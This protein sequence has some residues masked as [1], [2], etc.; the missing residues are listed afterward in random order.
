M[1]LS[2]LLRCLLEIIGAAEWGEGT[3]PGGPRDHLPEEQLDRDAGLYTADRES[4]RRGE[5]RPFPSA[6]FLLCLRQCEERGAGAAA[7][8]PGAGGGGGG[9]ASWGGRR[10]RGGDAEKQESKGPVAV[11][12]CFEKQSRINPRDCHSFVSELFSPGKDTLVLSHKWETCN[13]MKI[14]RGREDR[15]GRPP[16]ACPAEALPSWKR[17][18]LLL[19]GRRPPDP[20]RPHPRHGIRA[21]ERDDR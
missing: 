19:A 14:H 10:G 11:S 8:G 13:V 16:H 7:A 4:G 1:R 6:A 17:D 21:R 15:R 12:W 9:T 20:E 2:S 5:G 3:G 18:T